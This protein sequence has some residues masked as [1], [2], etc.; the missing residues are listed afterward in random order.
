MST[1]NP[2]Q[3]SQEQLKVMHKPLINYNKFILPSNDYK[4]PAPVEKARSVTGESKYQQRKTTE[5]AGNTSRNSSRSYRKKPAMIK[6]LIQTK[7]LARSDSKF[8][9]GGS[10]TSVYGEELN[11]PKAVNNS[12]NIYNQITD[13]RQD[14][15]LMDKSYL[16]IEF[17]S[18]NVKNAGNSV[19][20]FITDPQNSI[21][22]IPQKTE[23]YRYTSR[24]AR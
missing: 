20:M 2:V 5:R 16:N 1:L 13:D 22:K 11:I 8:E 6:D 23:E 17:E 21:E 9:F 4:L 12:Y 15:P 7:C 3:K 24:F 10:R 18:K 19:S 14:G